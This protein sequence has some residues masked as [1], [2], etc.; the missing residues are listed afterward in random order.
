M[1]PDWSEL[2]S[3]CIKGIFS[4][5]LMFKLIGLS[6]CSMEI[7]VRPASVALLLTFA[8]GVADAIRYLKEGPVIDAEGREYKSSMLKGDAEIPRPL[9]L[10]DDT[11]VHVQCTETSMIVEVK[12]DLYKIGHH[13]SPGEFFLGEA[14]HSGSSRCRALPS[15]D[16]KYVIEAKLQDCGS[17]LTVSWCF[18]VLYQQVCGCF[19][20][21]LK[22]FLMF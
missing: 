14:V 21:C 12:A 7:V 22:G 9:Q 8:L 5:S 3:V 4:N 10:I 18:M 1:S 17:N 2:G 13:E 16:G 19:W 20:G 11:A 15:G 6:R